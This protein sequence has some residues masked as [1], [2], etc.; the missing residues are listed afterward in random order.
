MGA[1]TRLVNALAREAETILA[2]GFSK[3][4]ET[5]FFGGGTP[6]LTALSDL[7]RVI[8]PFKKASLLESVIE[9]TSEA[10]PS[11][12]MLEILKGMR[13]LGVN[14]LSLGVQATRDDLLKWLG[15]AHD[16]R[17]ADEALNNAFEA[18]FQNVSTDLMVGVPGQSEQDIEDSIDRLLSFPIKHLSCYLL[19]LPQTHRHYRDL[20]DEETQLRHLRLARA[21]LISEGF[22]HYEIS[23]YAKPGFRSRHNM[24]YWTGASY[25]GIGPSAH[26]FDSQASRRWKNVSS[27]ERYTEALESGVN[28]IEWSENLTDH[29]LKLERWLLGMRLLDGIPRTWFDELPEGEKQLSTLLERGS[30]E[31][32]PSYFERVRP[33]E[34]GIFM[35]DSILSWLKM[36]NLSRIDSSMNAHSYS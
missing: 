11:S 1:P 26:S 31:Q 35:T 13:C 16:A 10:N 23:N 7:E 2:S 30:L 34:S 27:I 14:R 6:T 17:K 18:G 4:F 12:A 22:E 5:V 28:A 36:E 9:W 15:R 25:L 29:Q 3:P 24:G 8:E 33:S 19:T 21:K 32:H 20:P